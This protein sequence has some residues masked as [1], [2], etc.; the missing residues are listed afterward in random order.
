VHQSRTAT[1]CISP[2]V[3][4]SEWSPVQMRPSQGVSVQIL[5]FSSL[6]VTKRWSAKLLGPLLCDEG[7]EL[8]QAHKIPRRLGHR[9]TAL[10]KDQGVGS[11]TERYSSKFKNNFSA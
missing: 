11:C 8:E 3:R 2:G 5:V 7:R 1:L 9:L 6:R 10:S 4:P